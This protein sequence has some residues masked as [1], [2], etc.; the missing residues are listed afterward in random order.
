MPLESIRAFVSYQVPRKEVDQLGKLLLHSLT[1]TLVVV[2][3]V[4]EDVRRM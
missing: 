2:V 4:Y 3:C 1:A